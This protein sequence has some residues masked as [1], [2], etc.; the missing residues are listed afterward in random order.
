MDNNT[1]DRMRDIAADRIERARKTP[2]EQETLAQARRAD[3]IS[4]RRALL[5][6]HVDERREIETS[7]ALTVR[8]LRRDG[9]SWARIGELLGVS[10]QAAEQRYS[11]NKS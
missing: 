2:G 1:A 11:V 4:A 10:R 6:K 5:A 3:R 8:L 9:V 7:I